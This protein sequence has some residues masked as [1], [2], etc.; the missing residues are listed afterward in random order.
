MPSV[1]NPKTRCPNCGTTID[2]NYC[3]H[4]GQENE[5]RIVSIRLLI[6]D[7][8]SNFFTLDARLPQTLWPLLVKPGFLTREYIAGR[9]ARYARPS[10][11]Y[12]AISVIFFFTLSIVTG[13][14]IDTVFFQAPEASGAVPDSVQARVDTLYTQVGTTLSSGLPRHIEVDWTPQRISVT[15]DSARRSS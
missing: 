13:G 9:R 8:I 12:L 7:A 3:P 11:L 1:R 2:D 14:T 6:E 10:R 4:C 5:N 15:D